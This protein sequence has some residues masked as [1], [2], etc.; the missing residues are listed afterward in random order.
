V[1]RRVSAGRNIPVGLSPS[2]PTR[3]TDWHR[4]SAGGVVWLTLNTNNSEMIFRCL[5]RDLKGKLVF[6]CSVSQ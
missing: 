2:H 1:H 5:L 6:T 4:D 3:R